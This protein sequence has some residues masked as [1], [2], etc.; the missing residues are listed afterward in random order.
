MNRLSPCS[1]CNR[2]VRFSDSSCPFCGEHQS[3]RQPLPARASTQGLKRAAL[4]AL[5]AAAT[6]ACGDEGG[7]T[8]D[9]MQQAGN[10]S[11]SSGSMGAGGSAPTAGMDTPLPVDPGEPQVQ[12][13]YGA[14]AA[15]AEGQ[16]G[17]P[18][19]NVPAGAGA[20]PNDGNFPQPMPVYGAPIAPDSDEAQ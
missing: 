19:V 16:G 4:F 12:P 20:A 14:I 3:A 9:V 7:D 6:A 13:L 5:T 1:G 17:M 11:A 8:D 18:G 2:H 15:P 10:P